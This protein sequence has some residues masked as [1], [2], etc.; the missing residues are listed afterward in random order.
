[1]RN[2]NAYN[3]YLNK[4]IYPADDQQNLMQQGGPGI[5]Q[6][7]ELGWNISGTEK[8]AIKC[9]QQLIRVTAGKHESYESAISN[10]AI[11]LSVRYGVN[12]VG[13]QQPALFSNGKR[14]PAYTL[15]PFSQQQHFFDNII[16]VTEFNNKRDLVDFFSYFRKVTGSPEPANRISIKPATRV[17]GLQRW[18]VAMA[19]VPAIDIAFII[20]TYN[21]VKNKWDG[22]PDTLAKYSQID[23]SKEHLKRM[24]MDFA[25]LVNAVTIAHRKSFHIVDADL[26]LDHPGTMHAEDLIKQLTLAGYTI[27]TSTKCGLQCIKCTPPGKHGITIKFYNKILETIQQGYARKNTVACKVSY[28]SNPTTQRLEAKLLNPNV[29]NNGM[30]RTELTFSFVLDTGLLV[31]WDYKS[32]MKENADAYQNLTH[33]LVSCSIHDHLAGMEPLVGRSVITYFPQT[34]DHKKSRKLTCKDK[35]DANK[36]ISKHPDAILVRYA[37]SYTNKMNGVAVHADLDG[38]SPDINSWNP[39]AM[40]IAACAMTGKDPILFTCVG[41]TERFFGFNDSIAKPLIRNLYFVATTIVRTPIFPRIELQTYFLH[42]YQVQFDLSRVNVR[43]EDL[44]FN[45]IIAK[46]LIKTDTLTEISIPLDYRPE[47]HN[48]TCSEAVEKFTGLSKGIKAASKDNMPTEP[49]RWT[50][51]AV[52][53]IGRGRTQRVKFRFKDQWVWLP[54]KHE[55][56]IR[57]HVLNKP[58][59]D[60][61]FQWG[62]SG[63]VCAINAIP[64]AE[65]AITPTEAPLKPVTDTPQILYTGA[66]AASAKIPVSIHGHI[67]ESGGFVKRNGEKPQC[68]IALVGELKRFWLPASLSERMFHMTKSK[69]ARPNTDYINYKLDYLAGCLLVKPDNNKIGVSGHSNAEHKMWVVDASTGAIVVDQQETPSSVAKRKNE[70]ELQDIPNKRRR[71]KPN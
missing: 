70:E 69:F 26:T 65:T 22:E 2:K 12:D 49:S 71:I 50:E 15:E 35:A 23:S 53:T 56:F 13:D 36:W 46:G 32:M 54:K 21:F 30:T 34:F 38:R 17:D 19:D 52:G 11:E 7:L 25:N 63:F 5:N 33:C 6:D 51:L 44:T 31:Y 40:V 43:A 8:L 24:N 59:V 45:P 39:T 41:G 66:V 20:D 68:F 28:L 1:M 14:R 3:Q 58:N 42:K 18:K 27:N 55:A 60:C 62:P 37:N 48:D 4:F 67:I 57:E 47:L 29:H 61:T 9:G 64:D 10:A 16:F